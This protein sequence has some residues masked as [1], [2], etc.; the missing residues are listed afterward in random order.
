MCLLET[1]LFSRLSLCLFLL[2]PWTAWSSVVVDFDTA[3]PL[4]PRHVELGGQL[5]AGDSV[6]AS[7]AKGRLGLM[8]GLDGHLTLA[9]IIVED[10]VGYEFGFGG[11]YQLMTAAQTAGI[12]DVAVATDLAIGMAGP[13]FSVSSDVKGIVSR[14]FRYHGKRDITL[15]ANAGLALTMVSI[16]D[17]ANDGQMGVLVGGTV[18]LDLTNSM[19]VAFDVA[20]R[21]SL[22]RIGLGLAHYF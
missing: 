9:G 1:P 18:A 4:Q 10:N 5:S 17:G 14:S 8:P 19:T 15:A 6:W 16:E 22:K 2:Y 20:Y 13:L 11:R 7:G 21:D 12:V 3:Q